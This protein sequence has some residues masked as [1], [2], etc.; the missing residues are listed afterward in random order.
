MVG[1]KRDRGK[2]FFR[3]GVTL[4]LFSMVLLIA[5][6]QGQ[7]SKV[8]IP[9][10]S[11]VYINAS[12]VAVSIVPSKISTPD[13]WFVA[14]IILAVFAGLVL[15]GYLAKERGRLDMGE[16]R[17]AIAG[18]LVV[19]FTILLIFSLKYGIMQTEIII[20]YI[21]LVGIVIGFYFGAKTAAENGA[22]PATMLT[23]EHVGFLVQ[24]MK[25]KIAITIRNGGAAEITVDMIYINEKPLNTNIPIRRSHIELQDYEWEC[26][27][28]YKI[29]IGTT[30][31]LTVEKTKKSPKSE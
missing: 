19:G 29:K 10:S 18:T 25:K 15:L 28:K 3:V 16:M 23:I 31:G 20:A 6:V 27:T 11:D 5:S 2:S 22:E 17:R 30:A 12:T 8:N 13:A 14:V 4:F 26:D 21:E 9:N 7:T 1:I 24:N